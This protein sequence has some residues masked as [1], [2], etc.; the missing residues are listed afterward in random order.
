MI[1]RRQAGGKD[2]VESKYR[3]KQERQKQRDLKVKKKRPKS[4][5]PAKRNYWK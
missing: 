5:T 1:V 4:Q 2:D 3:K